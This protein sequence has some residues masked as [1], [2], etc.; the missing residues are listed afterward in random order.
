MRIGIDARHFFYRQ[1][2]LYTYVTRLLDALAATGGEEEFRVILSAK[3][4]ATKLPDSPRLRRRSAWTPPHN[5]FEQVF[6]PLE[7]AAAGLDVLHS[8]DFIPPFRRNFKSVISVHDLAFR[9]YP[10]TITAESKRY[11]GQ[12]YR[13]VE[14]ADGIV[15]ISESTKRDMV[16]LLGLPA[17]RVTVTHLGVDS[18]YMPLADWGGGQRFC[19]DNGLPSSFALCVGTIEP[20][21]N[22]STLVEAWSILRREAEATWRGTKLVLAG[23]RGWLYEDV[24]TAIERRGLAGEIVFFEPQGP[25]H[26]LALYNTARLLVFPSLYEGFGLPPLEA[27]ACGLPV[28]CANT[29]SLPEVVGDA[30]LMV[31]PTDAAALAGAILRAATD[32]DLRRSLRERGL[33]QAAKFTWQTTAEQTLAVYRAVLGKKG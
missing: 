18:S 6:L 28:V 20:R 12:I 11:Y 9:L 16:R 23:R 33:R 1:A 10:E 13:A 29:S 8:T 31:E 15:A 27:M 2:G 14:S 32:E 24:F 22:L 26:L 17:E 19:E 5:R 3:D 21:K 30:A 7:L 25:Q 4:K